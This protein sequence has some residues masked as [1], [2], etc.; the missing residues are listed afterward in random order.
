MRALSTLMA[1]GFA[2][3]TAPAKKKIIKSTTKG[4]PAAR[5]HNILNTGG[6]KNSDQTPTTRPDQNG[7]KKQTRRTL[8]TE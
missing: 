4:S 6:D 5:M 3:S 1:V 2:L 7:R 8:H